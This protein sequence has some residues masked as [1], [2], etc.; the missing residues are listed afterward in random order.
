[1]ARGW[2][3]RTSSGKRDDINVHGVQVIED[4]DGVEEVI[5]TVTSSDPRERDRIA[6]QLRDLLDRIV[7]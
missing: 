6:G 5:V 4:N 2:H 3:V 7:Q 1:M